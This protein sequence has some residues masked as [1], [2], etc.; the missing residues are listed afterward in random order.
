[1]NASI[2]LDNTGEVRATLIL[3]IALNAVIP[4]ISGILCCIAHELASL[5]IV[6]GNEVVY[7]KVGSIGGAELID[8]RQSTSSLCTAFP[9]KWSGLLGLLQWNI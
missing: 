1:M 2:Q 3:V 6:E 5:K 8:L 4:N 7:K 9:Q